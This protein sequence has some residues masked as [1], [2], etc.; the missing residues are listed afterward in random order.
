M[1]AGQ[2]PFP[3]PSLPEK[4]FGH[5]A[6]EPSRWRNWPGDV[7]RGLVEVV[8]RMMRKS[9]EERYAAP[10]QVAQAL[11]PFIEAYPR[12][13]QAETEPSAQG[14]DETSQ[15]GSYTPPQSR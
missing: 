7:P 5:Q 8:Q 4:L 13:R 6:L 15:L 11:A 1:L 2:V 12:I 14:L 10:L 9:P 3:S